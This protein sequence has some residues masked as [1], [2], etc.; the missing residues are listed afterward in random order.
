MRVS[1]REFPPPPPPPPPG[2]YRP[3]PPPPPTRC[4]SQPRPRPT[5]PAAP[6]CQLSQR[7]GAAAAPCLLRAAVPPTSP[8]HAGAGAR[9]GHGPIRAPPAAIQ[10]WTGKAIAEQIHAKSL[11]AAHRQWLYHRASRHPQLRDM[12][13]K[14]SNTFGDTLLNLKIGGE[15][16]VVAQSRQYPDPGRIRARAIE[17]VQPRTARDLY[18]DTSRKQLICTL[19]RRSDQNV[20][21]TRYC[22]SGGREKRTRFHYELRRNI[23]RKNRCASDTV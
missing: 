5:H 15:H 16:I 14:P 21:E 22:C 7:R 3:P 11:D 1:M 17:L 10:T 8:I 20:R 9:P 2:F 19:H 18:D 23:E 12:Y 6:S 13:A 4:P